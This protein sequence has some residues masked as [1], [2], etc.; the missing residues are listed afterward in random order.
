MVN[1]SSGVVQVAL[2]TDDVIVEGALPKFCAGGAAQ[3]VDAFG[4]KGFVGPN[5]ST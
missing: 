3:V 4:S 1:V 2:I 5:Q